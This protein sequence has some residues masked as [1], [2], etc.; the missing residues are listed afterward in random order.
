MYNFI[1]SY[2]LLILFYLINLYY[3]FNKYWSIDIWLVNSIL[4]ILV[5]SFLISLFIYIVNNILF[6]FIYKIDL[7][8]I[9]KYYLG[10]S[11]IPLFLIVEVFN[12]NYS[13][14]IWVLYYIIII[15][16]YW[17]YLK[18]IKQIKK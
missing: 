9:N 1:F 5:I 10:L 3:S 2:I 16:F 13:I 14:I 17:Y 7:N 11:I 8:N 4:I 15:S 18:H 12:S 6:K